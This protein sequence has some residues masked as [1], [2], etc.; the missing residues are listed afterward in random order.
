[1]KILSKQKY[2]FIFLLEY[3]Y[4]FYIET[5]NLS[6]AKHKYILATCCPQLSTNTS[7]SKVGIEI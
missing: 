1:M 7:Q 4:N 2:R 3:K 5:C 6:P